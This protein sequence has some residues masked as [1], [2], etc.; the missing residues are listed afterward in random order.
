MATIRVG[1]RA[2]PLNA[3]EL[4]AG[5]TEVWQYPDGGKT[6]NEILP[7][8]GSARHKSARLYSLTHVFPPGSKTNDI[9]NTMIKPLIAQTLDGYNCTIFAYGQ[10]ASKFAIAAPR[11]RLPNSSSCRS[12]SRFLASS[13]TARHAASRRGSLSPLPKMTA[14]AQA[15]RRERN[16]QP[17]TSHPRRLSLPTLT[18]PRLRRC[19]RLQVARPSQ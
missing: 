17:I 5:D 3:K 4:A 16:P 14:C 10:T 6:L 15:S 18:A 2:R 9:H 7:D 13:S 1:I 19:C 11:R 8:T 12:C